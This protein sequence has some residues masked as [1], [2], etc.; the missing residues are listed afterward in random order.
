MEANLTP[1]PHLLAA[2]MSSAA[3]GAGYVHEYLDDWSGSVIHFPMS[4]SVQLISDGNRFYEAPVP[5]TPSSDADP[6]SVN[7]DTD[8]ATGASLTPFL[9]LVS[10][11][12][13]FTDTANTGVV[14]PQIASSDDDVR[15]GIRDYIRASNWFRM[16]SMEPLIG[17][18]GVPMSALHL[19]ERG[20]S[21]YACFVKRV[22]HTENAV[23]KCTDCGH[24]HN[25]L[26]RA[27]GHQRAK[28]GHKP[29]AC[30]DPGW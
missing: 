19:A 22:R 3:A 1:L 6:S 27:V 26:D 23:L 28:W 16:N 24:E 20:E 17:E 2:P 4:R 10:F 12:T 8:P 9:D 5:W 30:T 18:S 14:A 21:I 11:P 15:T 29:F 7:V 13:S 25:R